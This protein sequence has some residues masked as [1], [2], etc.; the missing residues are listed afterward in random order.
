MKVA[1]CGLLLPEEKGLTKRAKRRLPGISGH[2]VTSS[3]IDGID[4]N[5]TLSIPLTF[6]ISL[7]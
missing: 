2:K 1:F 4:A 5:L 6:Q 3:L 7:I